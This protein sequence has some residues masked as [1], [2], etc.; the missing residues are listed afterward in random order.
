MEN[1]L[2]EQ[3]IKY[4]E[5]GLVTIPII[6][7]RPAVEWKEY[8]NRLP[9]EKEMRLWFADNSEVTGI[10]VVTGKLSGVIVLDVDD[11]ANLKNLDIPETITVKT[12]NGR[13]YYF[14]IRLI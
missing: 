13:H 5:L 3:S 12:G 4:H 11:G 6:G 10:A 2:L 7:K 9:A 8:Q 1:N 14:I